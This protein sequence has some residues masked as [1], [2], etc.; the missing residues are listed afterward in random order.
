M[1]QSFY[2]LKIFVQCTFA[3]GKLHKPPKR[4]TQTAFHFQM[5]RPACHKLSCTNTHT[6]TQL[7][8]THTYLHISHTQNMLCQFVCPASSHLA[9]IGLSAHLAKC[10]RKSRDGVGRWRHKNYTQHMVGGKG[11]RRVSVRV[12]YPKKSRQ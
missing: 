11:R 4:Q 5:P 3:R 2:L 6:Q 7:I 8:D 10:R 1:L 12:Y 9:M